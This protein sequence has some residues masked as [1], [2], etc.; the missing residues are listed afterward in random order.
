M[1]TDINTISAG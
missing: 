1:A